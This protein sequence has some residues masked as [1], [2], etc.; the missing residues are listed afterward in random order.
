MPEPENPFRAPKQPVDIENLSVP[1]RAAMAA[2]FKARY[3]RT[4]ALGFSAIAL[5]AGGALALHEVESKGDTDILTLAGALLIGGSLGSASKHY[6]V[7]R[8]FNAEAEH[9][10]GMLAHKHRGE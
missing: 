3:A 1:E 10:I 2:L 5:S 9:R 8:H 6:R 4:M 7:Y